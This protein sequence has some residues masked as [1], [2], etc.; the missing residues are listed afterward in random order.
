MQLGGQPK[1]S[2]LQTAHILRLF[3]SHATQQGKSSAIIFLDIR[4]AFYRVLRE[5]VTRHP[6]GHLPPI[7][8]DL[9]SRLHLPRSAAAFTESTRPYS[10][11]EY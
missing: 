8:Y 3:Q 5:T 2:V 1:K 4:A 9:V 6:G 10:G 7:V 11:H